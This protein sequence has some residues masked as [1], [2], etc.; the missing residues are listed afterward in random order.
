MGQSF[1]WKN[2]K[3][4]GTD[5][6]DKGESGHRDAAEDLSQGAGENDVN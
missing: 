1:Q 5:T 4:W 3:T 6:E 2:F